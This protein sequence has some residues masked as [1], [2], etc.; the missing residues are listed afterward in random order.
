[1]P[2]STPRQPGAWRP[3][4]ECLEKRQ[5]PSALSAPGHG[6][7]KDPVPVDAVVQHEPP[8][9]VAVDGFTPGEGSSWHDQGH[10]NG[11]G[12]GAL[13]ETGA[14]QPGDEAALA[15]L[16]Q[17]DKHSDGSPKL[18]KQET[19]MADDDASGAGKSQKHAT[20]EQGDDSST[21]TIDEQ[22]QK[23]LGDAQSLEDTIPLDVTRVIK[24]PKGQTNQTADKSAKV[25]HSAAGK[26]S[27]PASDTSGPKGPADTAGD[28]SE[29]TA[30]SD[31]PAGEVVASVHV[32]AQPDRAARTES[33]GSSGD[34][35]PAAGVEA[36]S[37]D[38]AGQSVAATGATVPV[39]TAPEGVGEP[40]TAPQSHASAFAI[41]LLMSTTASRATLAILATGLAGM[42]RAQNVPS[43]VMPGQVEAAVPGAEAQMPAHENDQ[44]AGMGHEIASDPANEAEP[45][46]PMQS[47]AAAALS[48]SLDEVVGRVE[49]AL[50]GVV[51]ASSLRRLLPWLAGAGLAVAA[52]DVVRR[53]QSRQEKNRRE[54]VG[55]DH[56]A[57]TWL[58]RSVTEK[59]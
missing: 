29:P 5:L 25:D 34:T 26:G 15:L 24:V 38:A 42:D 16:D 46:T 22:I 53:Q 52:V 55:A 13:K 28:F 2:H 33:P 48:V 35:V 56:D 1:M 58:P 54:I 10:G 30:Q 23:A 14:T 57:D 50:D 31:L 32:Q 20:G 51:E 18:Y 19:D 3:T 59:A 43:V 4:I 44:V 7:D 12:H 47:L 6:H 9:H 45:G 17:P 49:R 41:D 40:T 36:R 11:D 37:D 21:G 27:D 8:G 39:A